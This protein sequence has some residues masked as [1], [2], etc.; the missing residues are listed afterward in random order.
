MQF[1]KQIPMR[2]LALILGIV[3]MI[4]VASC[5]H[6][7][8][9]TAQGPSTEPSQTTYASADAAVAALVSA[10]RAHSKD[11]LSDV[12][13][14]A[15]DDVINSGDE[16]E[17]RHTMDNF[18]KQY[19]EKHTLTPNPDGSLTLV[20][21]DKDWP[22]PIPIVKDSD[23][24]T[25]WRFDTDAGE[26]EIINRRVGQN[27]LDT[28]QTCLAIVDAQRDY[29]QMDPTGAGVAVYAQ[30]IVSD[31][32]TKNGLYW[33][34]KEGEQQSPLG[35][36]MADATDEGYVKA[37]QEAGKPIPYHGYCYHMLQSQ[38]PNAEGGAYD[39]V[40]NGKA[41]GGFALVAH[42]ADYGNSGVMTFI[43]NQDG[44]VYQKDL[45]EQTEAIAS[46][47]TTFDPDPSWKKSEPA[48]PAQ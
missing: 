34:A 7:K 48:T 29:I 3:S 47:M 10:A 15:A 45:G 42:P 6:S 11:Q 41:I 12:L 32:G 23:D 24:P 35:P 19:D 30:K 22:M 33:D 8:T 5:N 4:V 26:D 1:S 2:Y 36:L 18:V 44:V 13:G 39:Y 38:G 20:I 43:V 14:P 28:M 40:V 27:E 46:A 21:G 17:D 37:R 16:V 9:E 31:A 25:P